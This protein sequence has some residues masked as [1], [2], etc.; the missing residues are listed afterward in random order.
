MKGAAQRYIGLLQEYRTRLIADV[1]TGKLDV[2]DAAG[3]LPDCVEA[4]ERCQ[5][6]KGGGKA[7]GG[8][9]DAQMEEA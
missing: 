4:A 9:S 7:L 1:V 6:V 5:N 3:D 8:V 2:R